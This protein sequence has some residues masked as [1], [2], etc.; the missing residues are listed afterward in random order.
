MASDRS[1]RTFWRYPAESIVII[2]DD[3]SKC[4]TASEDLQQDRV[5][6]RKTMTWMTLTLCRPRRVCMCVCVCVSE[7]LNKKIKNK[8]LARHSGSHL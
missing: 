7:F 6:R 2:G 1:F 5:W 3:S 4:I 8:V